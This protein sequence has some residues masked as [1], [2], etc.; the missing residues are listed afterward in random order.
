VSSIPRPVRIG[1][2]VAA[3]ALLLS[4]CAGLRPGTAVEVGEEQITSSELDSIATRYCSAASESLDQQAQSI[5]NGYIRS[6]VAGLLA[7][8]EVAEQVAAE[9]GVEV[10]SDAYRQQ[11]AD[12]RNQTASLPESHQDAVL[13]VEGAR[14]Y[15]TAAQTAI[16]QEV[17]GGSGEESELQAAG[18]EEMQRWIDENGVEFAPALN[19]TMRD[20]QP[21]PEDGSLSFAVSEGAKAGQ[22]EQP[23]SAVAAALPDSQ[24]CGR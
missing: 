2:A 23:N 6:G 13:S 9:R 4:G 14:I 5:P 22:A 16:G 12:V 3:A 18:A 19:V 24:R 11:L 10:E 21:A 17:L 7:M 1:G 15:T 20:G 8:R